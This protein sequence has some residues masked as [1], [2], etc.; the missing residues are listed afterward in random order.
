ML[1]LPLCGLLC[2]CVVCVAV[3]R[4][5]AV[6]AGYLSAVCGGVLCCVGCVTWLG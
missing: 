2:V 1:R 5:A 4:A 3:C 6:L